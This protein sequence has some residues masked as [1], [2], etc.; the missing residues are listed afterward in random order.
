MK[1]ST[2]L[3]ASK[4]CPHFQKVAATSGISWRFPP[5][6]SPEPSSSF[7]SS[8]SQPGS[9]DAS[10]PCP[11]VGPKIEGKVGQLAGGRG[12]EMPLDGGRLANKRVQDSV[13]DGGAHASG[14]GAGGRGWGPT[15]APISQTCLPN[16]CK[17]LTAVE[18][19]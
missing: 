18:S 10:H 14:G 4:L 1:L 9:V 13:M 17:Q 19:G 16:A 2:C 7:S 6:P 3:F 12:P 15:M 5:P 8:S 11:A